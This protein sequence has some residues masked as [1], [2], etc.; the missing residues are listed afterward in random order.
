[1]TAR[2]GQREQVSLA[3][4]AGSHQPGQ[5]SSPQSNC[6]S[7][8]ISCSN[9]MDAR[10]IKEDQSRSCGGGTEAVMSLT[11]PTSPTKWKHQRQPH[12]GPPNTSAIPQLDASGDIS[13][14]GLEGLHSPHTIASFHSAIVHV[15][16]A[17]T[18]HAAANHV[19]ATVGAAFTCR[20]DR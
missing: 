13:V 18:I 17:A 6:S 10:C 12:D 14:T 3:R 1:M 8:S 19:A 15:H 11:L 4:S 5:D 9:V 16:A 20:S 2:T 7:Y